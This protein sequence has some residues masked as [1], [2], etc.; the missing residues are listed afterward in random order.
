MCV[1]LFEG[2]GGTQEVISV[3]WLPCTAVVVV[4]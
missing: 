1:S 3:M 2:E 4:T